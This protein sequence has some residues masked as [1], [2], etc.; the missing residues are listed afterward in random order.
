MKK[1]LMV[2][3]SILMVVVTTIGFSACSNKYK[4]GVQAGT[5]GEYY[6]KGD[7]DWEFEGFS[8]IDCKGYAN[9]GLAVN[10]MKNGKVDYVI[11]DEAPAKYLEKNVE[12]I[13]VIDIKLTE[14]EYAF[15]VNKDDA[16]L[17]ASVNTFLTTIM[18]DGTFDAVVNKYFNGGEIQG[19][20]SATYDASK[21]DKQLV[22]ATNAGFAP[23]EYKDGNKF[24][25]IDMEIAKLLADYLQMELVISDMEFDAV[26]TSVGKNGVDIA[27]AGL[28]INETRKAS[29]NFS[30]TYYNASQMLVCLSSDTT[31]DACKTASELE[32]IIKGLTK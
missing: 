2:M 22:V 23:F 20:T 8:N 25:G 17:L 24:V 12:G 16:T 14:E 21:Q 1:I 7:T 26:V 19:I 5:V 18:N 32:T 28:T 27:M 6:V 13:K 3:V 30:N 4:I 31:F 29:V 10:D 15:G 9:A 11:V